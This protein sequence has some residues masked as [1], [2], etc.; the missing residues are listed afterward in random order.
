MK[1]YGLERKESCNRTIRG[2]NRPCPCCVPRI[3]HVDPRSL[4]K[5]E[6]N[7]G[8]KTIKEQNES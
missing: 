5:R 1:A 7:R 3:Q 6:R 8:K 4:R 2:T